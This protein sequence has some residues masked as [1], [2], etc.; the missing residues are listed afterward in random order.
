MPDLDLPARQTAPFPLRPARMHEAE[1]AGRRIFALYQ[2]MHHPGPLFW[3]LRAH[4]RGLPFLW[5]LPPGIADRL[6]LVLAAAETDLLWAAEETLRSP[7]VGLV[8]AEPQEHLSLTAGRRLQLAAESGHT[9]AIMLIR[10]GAGSN[11]AETRWH[12]RPLLS[13]RGQVLHEWHLL[14][15]K[16]GAP[17]AWV[18]DWDGRGRHVAVLSEAMADL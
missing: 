1:G 10:Q 6:Y 12:C 16:R 7:A 9:T 5:G 3:I 11:A 18:L 4:E 8:V 13:P 2:A 14:R 15:D 17:K